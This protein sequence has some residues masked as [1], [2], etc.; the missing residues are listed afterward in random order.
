MLLV[1]FTADMPHVLVKLVSNVTSWVCTKCWLIGGWETPYVQPKVNL[2]AE[3]STD[4]ESSSDE[5]ETE[6]SE[7]MHSDKIHDA[8]CRNWLTIKIDE[9]IYYRMYGVVCDDIGSESEDSD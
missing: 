4:T 1:S 7:E 6:S 8:P 2:F 5:S 9:Q 3:S